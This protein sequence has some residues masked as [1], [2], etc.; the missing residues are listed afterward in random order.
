LIAST[1][2]RSTT[3][4]GGSFT[5][6]SPSNPIDGSRLKPHDLFL[7]RL[8]LF[9]RQNPGVDQFLQLLDRLDLLVERQALSMRDGSGN[10]R[11]GSGSLRVQD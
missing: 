2:R 8:E 7:L 6:P 4:T 5:P 10:L 11:D 9:L 3:G 1:R